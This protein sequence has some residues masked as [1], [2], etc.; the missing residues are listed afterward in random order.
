MD[1]G[2]GSVSTIKKKKHTAKQQVKTF[3]DEKKIKKGN[4]KK[5]YDPH[6][7]LALFIRGWLG[8]GTICAAAALFGSFWDAVGSWC[9]CHFLVGVQ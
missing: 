6:S 7:F 4:M 9:G 1:E 2:K 3:G 8:E 5:K